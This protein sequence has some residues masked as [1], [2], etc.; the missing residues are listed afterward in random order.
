MRCRPCGI[1]RDNAAFGMKLCCR[2]WL[3]DEPKLDATGPT[4]GQQDENVGVLEE[5]TGTPRAFV[6]DTTV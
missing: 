4:H 1:S 6:T 3:R 5:A 2:K